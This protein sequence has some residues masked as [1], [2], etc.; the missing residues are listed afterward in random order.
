M[1]SSRRLRV[2]AGRQR[3]ASVVLVPGET[4]VLGRDLDCDVV[5]REPGLPGTLLRL[6]SDEDGGTRIVPCADGVRVDGLPLES[7]TTIGEGAQVEAGSLVFVVEA[8][9]AG[10]TDASEGA[11]GVEPEADGSPLATAA[12]SPSP[13][14][15]AVE[16]AASA[17]GSITPDDTGEVAKAFSAA[18][19]SRLPLCLGTA[20]TLA[21]L[22]L[23][24]WFYL[25][26]SDTAEDGVPLEARLAEAFPA[27]AL[28]REPGGGGVVL[29]FVP[30]RADAIRLERWLAAQPEP[31]RNAVL[32]DA[33]LAER[34]DDVLR[35][36]GIEASVRSLI[37]GEAIV[38]TAVADA[39]TLA[40]IEARLDEDVPQLVSLELANVPPV[41]PPEETPYDPGKRVALVVATAPAY[42]VTKDRSRYFVGA[43]LPSGHRIRAIEENV[44]H[45]EKGGVT[46]ELQ[47]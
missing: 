10:S 24:V 22:T 12:A 42:I 26:G 41:A 28:E 39:E 38:D 14:L 27:L 44:V 35:V 3:G 4:L 32:V 45:L 46:S 16:R 18:R 40:R 15:R 1:K 31:L 7:A 13:F 6:E 17:G 9:E 20:A 21:C 37:E 33:R 25:A 23:A 36:N 34:V 5:V 30:E 43:M 47:F 29:G 8:F 11:S 19:P 2:L